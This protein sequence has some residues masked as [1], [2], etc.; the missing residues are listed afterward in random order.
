VRV[1][2]RCGHLPSTHT[3]G[4]CGEMVIVAGTFYRCTC[5]GW[6]VTAEVASSFRVVPDDEVVGR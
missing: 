1:C 3:F 6:A 5:E 4:P 2:A